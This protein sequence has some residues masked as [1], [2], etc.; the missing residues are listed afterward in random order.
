MFD[1]SNCANCEGIDCMIRCQWIEFDNKDAAKAE[2]TKMI[3]GEES[4]VLNECVTCLACD[5]YCPYGS[6]PF[7]LIVQLQ[8]K[9][10]SYNINP[11]LVQRTIDMFEP[12]EKLKLKAIK[13][14]EPV[15]SKCAL[16]KMCGENM[17]GP[18]FENLQYVSGT[19]FFCNLM[20]LHVAKDSLI[21]ERAPILINNI[22]KQ[23]VQDLICFHDE[24]YGFWASYCSRNNITLPSNFRPIHLFEYLY[25]NLKEHE[26]EI[27][28]LNVKIAYQRSCSNRF[29]PETDKWV[30]KICELIGVERVKRKYDRENAL[31]CTAPF[32]LLGKRN[33]IRETQ[34]KNV[35]DMIEYE[36]EL[37]VYNCPFCKETMGSKVERKGLKNYLLSDLCRLAL[38]EKLD[39]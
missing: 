3:N 20:Y 33:L 11:Q 27:K 37:C 38:G 13:S 35:N 24:C 17:K 1:K 5:E 32:A 21:K 36:A 23:N 31:C 16:S 18:L 12:H 14:D 15:L 10:N 22:E 7:D 34:N 30:D 2:M 8:E 25:N 28:K 9:F 26:S 6:H 39:Y 4:R 29:H 19:D